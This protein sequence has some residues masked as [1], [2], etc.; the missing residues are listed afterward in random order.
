M[1]SCA[2]D[3]HTTIGDGRTDIR[4]NGRTKS[5]KLCTSAFLR[6][7]GAQLVLKSD[8]SMP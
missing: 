8:S 6:K 4:T 5:R 7:G 1:R 2:H 3:V